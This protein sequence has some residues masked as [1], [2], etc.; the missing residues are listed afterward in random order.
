MNLWL[1]GILVLFILVTAIRQIYG[2]AKD[3][4]WLI[5]GGRGGSPNPFKKRARSVH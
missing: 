1:S 4:L 5:F 3:H 2:L